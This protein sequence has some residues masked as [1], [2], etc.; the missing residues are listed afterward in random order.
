MQSFHLMRRRTLPLLLMLPLAFTDAGPGAQPITARGCPSPMPEVLT[1][2]GVAD[3]VVTIGGS[4]SLH[5][6]INGVPSQTLVLTI[7][8]TYTFDL[9]AFGDEHPFIINSN[10]TNPW[11]TLFLPAVSGNVVDFTPIASMP[12]TI[13][14]HCEVHYGSMVGTIQLQAPQPC[15]G[16]LNGDLHVNSADFSSFIGAYGSSCTNCPADMDHNGVV[17][18]VDFTMFIG[19]F[20]D[21][22]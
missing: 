10:A 14:Y 18:V 11:G 4:P 6:I 12:G 20:G 8:H 22:C 2:T 3:F 13:Y 21:N 7:G 5:Y 15:P 17:G 19:A 1:V 9:T 16:D